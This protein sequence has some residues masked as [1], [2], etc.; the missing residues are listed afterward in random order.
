M[1][2]VAGRHH[3]N[4]C[5]IRAMLRAKGKE[6]LVQLGQYHLFTSSRRPNSQQWQL[7]Q[8]FN[9][10]GENSGQDNAYGNSRGIQPQVVS[11][12]ASMVPMPKWVKN[13]TMSESFTPHPLHGRRFSL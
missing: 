7:R 9:G 3:S 8:R 10:I 11:P 5:E 13:H 1:D 4:V 2:H 12:H 6:A